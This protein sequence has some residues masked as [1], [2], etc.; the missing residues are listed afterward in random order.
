MEEVEV[1]I[2]MDQLPDVPRVVDGLARFL[3]LE[4]HSLGQTTTIDRLLDTP[5]RLL[6]SKGH[7]LRLRQKLENVY[8]GKELRLTYKRPLRE[9]DTLF[10]RE[11]TKLKLMEGDSAEAIAML[12]A[13]SLGLAGEPLKQWL[14]IEETARE[15]NIGPKGSRVRVSV[16]YCTYS[17]PDNP[18]AKEQEVV[19]ELESHGVPEGVILNACDWVLNQIGGRLASENKYARGLKLLGKM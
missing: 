19:F 9:H 14:L 4:Q 13:L 18:R 5:E 12:G 2:L 7:S 6:Q 17:L 15:A 16:D 8:A 10:I 1:E 11:E 3:D